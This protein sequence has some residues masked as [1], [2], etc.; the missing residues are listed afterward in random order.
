MENIFVN[1]F[2]IIIGLIIGIIMGFFIFK[3]YIYKGLNADSITKKIFNDLDGKKSMEWRQMWWQQAA[4]EN[5]TFAFY[6]DIQ[7]PT[8]LASNKN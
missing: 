6:H 3:K 7:Y 8:Y 5:W 4:I 2:T 1:I